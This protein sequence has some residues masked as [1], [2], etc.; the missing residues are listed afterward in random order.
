MGAYGDSLT[1]FSKM[2][3]ITSGATFLIPFIII[4]VF[5][6]LPLSAL[7]TA[8]GQYYQK[9]ALEI[10]TKYSWRYVGTVFSTMLNTSILSTYYIFLMAYCNIYIF[11]A[12]FDDIKWLKSAPDQVLLDVQ[13]YWRNDILEIDKIEVDL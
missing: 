12:I 9:P 2:G 10:Y 5:C 7:D 13:T 1:S 8:I 6:V 11:M 4:L 3:N